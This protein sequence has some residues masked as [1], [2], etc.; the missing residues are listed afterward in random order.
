MTTPEQHAPVELR[1]QEAIMAADGGL[2]TPFT[3]Q[4][5]RLVSQLLADA[6]AGLLREGPWVSVEER[7]PEPGDAVWFVYRGLAPG[8]ETSVPG[9]LGYRYWVDLCGGEYAPVVVTHW[10]PRYVEP[11]P[12]PPETKP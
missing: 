4:Q 10:K 7:M 8:A 9:S 2:L 3:P 12:A 5:F 6:E 1:H 11:A